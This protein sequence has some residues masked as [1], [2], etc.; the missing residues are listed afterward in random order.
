MAAKTKITYAKLSANIT[1]ARASAKISF[2]N[3]TAAGILLDAYPINQYFAEALPS[4]TDLT[5]LQ[6]EKSFAD[7]IAI[8]D[9]L[10]TLLQIQIAAADTFDFADTLSTLLTIQ[11]AFTE[12]VSFAE[13]TQ[14]NI[15][16]LLGDAFSFT[17]NFGT[18]VTTNATPDAFAITDSSIIT[19][20]LHK[21]DAVSVSDAAT[22]SFEKHLTDGFAFNE[23]FITGDNFFNATNNIFGFADNLVINLRHDNAVLNT[24]SLNTFSLNS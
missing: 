17:D 23:N 24:S 20:G 22:L 6:V 1:Y 21:S 19:S 9:D 7:G 11:R 13:T 8:G 14:F 18:L 10:T 16:K 2:Q 12:T 3:L 15:E 4:F 5:T